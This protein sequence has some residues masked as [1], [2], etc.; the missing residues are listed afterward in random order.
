MSNRRI[1]NAFKSVSIQ[2]KLCFMPNKDIKEKT[3]ITN[4]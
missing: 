2:L 3:V 1:S 4:P